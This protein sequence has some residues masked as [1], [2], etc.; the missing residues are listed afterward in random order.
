MGI[1]DFLNSKPS[2][3]KLTRRIVN[4]VYNAVQTEKGVRVE[5]AICVMATIVAERCITT[6]NE[7]SIYEHD[8]EPGSAVFSE[9]MNELL[10]GPVAVDH[11]ND[12]PPES[13]F[14]RIK[15][16]LNSHFDKVPFPSLQTIFET[17]AKNVGAS[18]WGYLTLSVPDENKPFILPLQAGYE[19]R[20]YVDQNINL[21]SDEKTLRIVI[22]AL[23]HI[24]IET[25]TAL[26]ASIS[27]ALTFEIINGMSKTATMTDKKMMELQA[28]MKK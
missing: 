28:E 13:V 3:E 23:C 15:R 18:E 22:N 2:V 6:A 14:A 12:L 25:K 9:K 11:W 20:K 26:D 27:L 17:Y 7:F 19:T 4:F 8:F 10:V 24:L 1:F 5:D 16:K 21:E